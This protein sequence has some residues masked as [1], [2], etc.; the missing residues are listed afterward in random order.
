MAS[1]HAES[2]GHS[3]HQGLLLCTTPTAGG[4]SQGSGTFA[5]LQAEGIWCLAHHPT[6]QQPWSLDVQCNHSCC[7]WF[8]AGCLHL[9]PPPPPMTAHVHCGGRV[10]KDG[11]HGLSCRRSVGRLPC[12]SPLNTIV[13]QSL[14][15]ANIPSVLEPQGLHFPFGWQTP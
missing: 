2:Q 4:Q 14:A 11:L 12:H 10:D 15:S 1:K 6:N 3:S 9:F 8:T 5:G 13:K 7:H